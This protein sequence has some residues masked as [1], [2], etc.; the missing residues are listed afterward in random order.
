MNKYLLVNGVT[1]LSLS[2]GILAVYYS[3]LGFLYFSF[4]LVLIAFALDILD[5]FLARK[6]NAESSFGAIFDTISDIVVYLIYLSVLLYNLLEVNNL[7]GI[8]SIGIFFFAGI[9]RL[10][11]FTLQGFDTQGDKKYYSGL[12]VVF[13]HCLI[14]I[15]LLINIIDKAIISIISPILLILLSVLMVSKIKIRKP[16]KKYLLFLVCFIVSV[17]IIM[18]FL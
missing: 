18:L 13:S 8:T 16:L 14:A 6:L 2:V 11:R 3:F 5:G 17:S 1:L 4:G 9:F 10:V 15:I 12:P 7:I